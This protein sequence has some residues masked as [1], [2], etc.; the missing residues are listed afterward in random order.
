MNTPLPD[1]W[2]KCPRAAPRHHLTQSVAD[3]LFS[4]ADKSGGPDACWPWMA[5]RDK[6]NYGRIVIK[7]RHYRAHRIAYQISKPGLV[8][9]LCVCH[10]CDNPPCVNPAHLF[11]GT[12]LDNRM[13]SVKK[14]RHAFGDRHGSRLHPERLA[15]GAS[16]GSRTHPERVARG[17][18]HNSRTH[19]ECLKRG[20]ENHKAKLNKQK[21]MVIRESYI[22]RKVTYDALAARF[23][24]TR[25]LV[26]LV[27]TRKIWKHVK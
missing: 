2:L 1:T 18:R 16:H 3:R 6:Y 8:D 5:L 13:D 26:H 27:V 25:G 19:P 9:G 22:P 17:E 11:I 12:N 15:R 14:A 21:V 4:R 20:E 24:V 10:K 7:R 23:G